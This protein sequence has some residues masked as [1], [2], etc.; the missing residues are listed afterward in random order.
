MFWKIDKPEQ[1]EERLKHYGKWLLDNWDWKHPVK[2]NTTKYTN[3]RS[4]SQNALLHVWCKDLSDYFTSR[5]HPISPEEV[6]MLMKHLFLGYE[7]ILIGSTKIQEQLRKTSNLD[8][9]ELNH[10][11]SQIQ[12]WASDKGCYLSCDADSEYMKY[13]E[14]QRE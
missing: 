12:E 14:A 6:K 9:G 5:N 1:V 4:L 10:F 11:L 7:T 3:P 13:K 2:I 8:R